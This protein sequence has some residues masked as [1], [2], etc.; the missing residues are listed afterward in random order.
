MHPTFIYAASID[1]KNIDATLIKEARN[2][3]VLSLY[4]KAAIL[5]IMHMQQPHP[6]AHI[7]SL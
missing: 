4:D 5:Q 3:H 6:R 2:H 1:S 7:N